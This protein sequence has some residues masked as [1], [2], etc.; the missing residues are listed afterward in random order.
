MPTK[1]ELWKVHPHGPLTEVADHLWTVDAP[2]PNAAV[3]RRMTVAR[4]ED[5]GLVVHSAVAADDSI[6]ARIESLGPI[7]FIVVPSSLHRIDGPRF[8]ARYP[9]AKVV[10][11]RSAVRRISERVPVDL[12]YDQ[13][14]SDA[15]VSLDHL[16]G[17]DEAEGVLQIRGPDGTTVVFN[18]L[19]FN[20]K[21]MPGLIGLIY[22]RW[23]GNTGRPKVTTIGRVFVVRD[24]PRFRA[25]LER[26]AAMPDLRRILMSHGDP[27]LSD[28]QAT[29]ARVAAE[30]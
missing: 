2:M 3:I 27:I 8:K 29:L 13:F 25:H 17:V 14:P 28:A 26:L 21:A 1:R 10:A 4:M 30:L 18:D 22:G 24:R 9:H 5:G 16:D 19:L 11:P 6:M 12:T 23:M 7:R 15:R 20:L